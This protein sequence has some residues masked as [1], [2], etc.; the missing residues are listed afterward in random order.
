MRSY[1]IEWRFWTKVL[2]VESGCWEWQGY[3][4]SAGYGSFAV[5]PCFPARAPRYAYELMVGDIPEGLWVCH[6]CDNPPCVRPEHLF[7][8]TALDNHRDMIEKGRRKGAPRRTHCI[9]GHEFNEKNTYRWPEQPT[10]QICRRCL[11]IRKRKYIVR[12][13]AARKS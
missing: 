13:R 1:P 6:K 8:G 4:D 3:R 7:L 10:V 11:Y 5:R 2:P 12:D 9:N